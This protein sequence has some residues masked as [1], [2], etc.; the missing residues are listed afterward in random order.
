MQPGRSRLWM[1]LWALLGGLLV[2]D[3]ASAQ[4]RR[5]T[6]RTVHSALTDLS[7]SGLRFVYSTE[8]VP[9]T[10]V[11]SREP[12]S[13]DRLRLANEILSDFGL[14]ARPVRGDL[15]VVVHQRPG[16]PA[17]RLLGRVL[18]A[19]SGSAIPTA[20]VELQP[21]GIVRVTDSQG[22]FAFSAVP[23]ASYQLYVTAPD[24]DAAQH[25]TNFRANNDSEELTLRVERAALTEVVVATSRYQLGALRDDPLFR[26]NRAQIS[27]QPSVASDPLRAAN[28]L[29]GFAQDG[30]SAPPSIRG[31][32][33][34]EV[35]TLL[36]GFPLRQ[37]YHL[38]GYQS[39]LSILDENVI[40]SMEIYTG[41][42][43]AHYGNRLAGVFDLHTGA[44]E[45]EP[46]SSV[47]IGFANAHARLA[48]A[49]P[50]D[51]ADVLLAGRVGTLAPVL[52]ALSP[53]S[54]RPSYSDA[55]ARL[56]YRPLPELE[57]SARALWASDD[58][59][60]DDD[61]ER[62]EFSSRARYLWLQARWWPNEDLSATFWLG[63]SRLDL[64]RAGVV[65]KDDFFSGAA[66]DTR[67]A[68]LTD[69]RS[70]FEWRLN[71]NHR[72]LL[73]FDWT[74]AAGRY[75]YRSNVQFDEPAIDLFASPIADA[76]DIA[77]DVGTRRLAVFASDRWRIGERW[78]AE[79]G[80]RAQ[81]PS[82][83]AVSSSTTSIDPR[84]GL[85]WALAPSTHL[86]L[87]WGRFSQVDE[88]H[89]LRIEDGVTAPQG[90]RRSEHWIV[91]LEHNWQGGLR[92]RAEAFR[93]EDS[94]PR[95]RFENTMTRLALLP[96]LTP[97]RTVLAPDRADMHGVEVSLH[98]ERDSWNA[99]FSV[100]NSKATDTF[101]TRKVPRS[102]DQRWSVQTGADWRR[103][104]WS[105]S[106][107]LHWHSGW[108]STPL[109]V[110]ANGDSAVG[111]RNSARLRSFASLDLRADYRRPLARGSLL[112]S[113]HL[114]NAANRKNVCCSDLNVEQNLAGETVLVPES[115]PSLPLLPSL[116]IKWEF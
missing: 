56:N 71:D 85:R 44:T 65:A 57:L 76:R 17:R 81:R 7:D 98:L 69:V 48:R 45:R 92:L 50:I 13:R 80:V 67:Q 37:P 21:L 91:G 74:R 9:D 27:A 114:S 82:D 83:T 46:Q 19:Q 51:G 60:I 88:A 68:S 84:L 32:E 108:P 89:E 79:F 107:A 1:S 54:P 36:D 111:D 52:A 66:Q 86:R 4:G 73:G 3:F 5:F 22:R 77:L 15:Y 14:A 23:A 58:L 8:L 35:L 112:L 90:T 96:E 110:D 113:L 72:A 39:L 105:A 95:V 40:D 12:R 59:K 100:N 20:R 31:S 63:H 11:I 43:G 101:G 16:P 34:S 64:A 47:G 87:N 25:P 42:F 62:A 18:D 61:D 97:D 116:A 55:F 78:I 2:V 6:G 49:L 75:A 33:P 99:W 26:L 106:A 93:K 103:G 53:R 109:I 29:P 10:L 70:H 24:Y 41:G 94:R 104:P 102:W 38:S 28:R 30:I 115:Q